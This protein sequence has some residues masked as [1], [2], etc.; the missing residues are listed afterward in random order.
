MKVERPEIQRVARLA[1][2]QF[3]RMGN[4]A[5][6]HGTNLVGGNGDDGG[7]LSRERD[8][9]DLI[10]L[11]P[12]IDVNDSSDVADLKPFVGEKR[13]QNHPVVFVNH[14]RKVLGRMRRDKPRCIGAAV[15]D[16]DGP[17]GWRAPV[18]TTNRT[19][20]PIFGA[21]VG[22]GLRGN[23]M[24]P[25]MDK[26]RIRQSLPLSRDE[27]EMSEEFRLARSLRVLGRK[28]VIND[29]GSFDNGTACVR[30]I[31]R[32]NRKQTRPRKRNFHP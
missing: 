7:R 5:A 9:L 22:F 26:Q 18:W 25:G 24:R 28:K 21:V 31:H 1:M 13:G 23:R 30:K 14:G 32:S 2:G 4:L 20:D 12:R 11:V 16:P 15:D 29:L 3:P 17:D 19:F 6:S 27:P 10:S 8:E